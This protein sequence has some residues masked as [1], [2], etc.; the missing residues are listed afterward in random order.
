MGVGE[1]TTSLHIH[2]GPGSQLPN[3]SRVL[4][5]YVLVISKTS[6]DGCQSVDSAP[7]SSALGCRHRLT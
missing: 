7:T 5:L 4:W 1:Y 6:K 3:F 2:T